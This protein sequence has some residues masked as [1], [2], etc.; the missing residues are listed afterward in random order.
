MA[1]KTRVEKWW[2]Q[3]NSSLHVDFTWTYMMFENEFQL[4][5]Q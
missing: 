2:P 4:V 5:S 3:A 1:S